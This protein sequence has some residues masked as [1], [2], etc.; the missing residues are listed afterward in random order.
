MLNT[1]NQALWELQ[2]RRLEAYFEVMDSVEDLLE[3]FAKELYQDLKQVFEDG[4][5]IGL[6]MDQDWIFAY[7]Q[8]LETFTRGVKRM[9]KGEY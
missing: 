6:T 3:P 5:V 7:V 2:N 8:H 1:L 9:V 4:K